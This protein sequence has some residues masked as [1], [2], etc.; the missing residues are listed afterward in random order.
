MNGILLPQP[1]RR[2]HLRGLWLVACGVAVALAWL[3]TGAAPRLRVPVAATL[4]SVTALGL[5]RPG[6][7]APLY[8]TWNRLARAVGARV[9]E[10]AIQSAYR[11]VLRAAG[12]R[13]AA[14][15]LRLDR[16]ERGASGWVRRRT[17]P[18]GDYVRQHGATSRH[19]NARS[20]LAASI[21]TGA[22][23]P[24]V[25]PEPDAPSPGRPRGGRRHG[26]RSRRG[27]LGPYVRWCVE[28]GAWA[29][30]LLPLFVLLRLLPTGDTRAG[31]PDGSTY[32]L[33]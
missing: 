10:L 12:A 15:R 18:G 26:L 4:L 24:V 17:Q 8:R 5:L 29:L 28:G 1:P 30:G 13:D 27:F 14:L 25:L 2:A 7:T 31:E 19:G 33:Y 20:G 3:A 11:A 22:L 9:R 32:T 21:V 16:P 23:P 6:I